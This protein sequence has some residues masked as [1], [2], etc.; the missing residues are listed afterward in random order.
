MLYTFFDVETPN[1]HNDRICSIGAVVTDQDGAIVEKKSYLVNPESGFDDINIRI[2]GIAPTDV[3]NAKTFPELWDDSLSAFFP[4]DGVVAHNARFDLGVLT[5]T[6]VSYGI[7]SPKMSYAC[8]LDMSKRIDFIGGG[9]LPQ[10]CEALGIDL[11]KHHQA[12]SDAAACMRVFWTLVRMTGS[13]PDFIAYE[14]G[15]KRR[16]QSGGQHRSVSDKTK[17]MQ[18]LIPLL[19]EV[20]SNGEVSTLEAE[21]VLEFFG[22]HE[23]L[24]SDPA[25]SPVVSLLQNAIAD[26]WID[27][28][29]SNELAGLI[30]HIVN[31]SNSIEGNVGFADKKFVL[32]GSFNHGTK[33]DVSAF[34]RGRGGEVLQSV[35]KKCDYVVIGG[36]GSEAYS[37][38]SYGGK[39]KKAL[40]WQAK[41]VPMQVIEECD[42]YGEGK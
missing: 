6:L 22:L 17:A 12:E 34:I 28:A 25:L 41:G 30:S 5:K 9:K 11:A 42:L 38:D 3:L 4:V 21:A 23:E 33:D 18:W 27:E 19:E 36:C 29:E 32:T 16:K 15:A 24:A 39:V 10:V 40:D 35:T 26:G 20:V 2:H 37:L 31:P 1:R 13:M 7:P 14:P 8:T